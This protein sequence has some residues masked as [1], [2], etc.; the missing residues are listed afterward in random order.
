MLHELLGS[1]VKQGEPGDIKKE[2]MLTKNVKIGNGGKRSE[3]NIRTEAGNSYRII[4]VRNIDHDATQQ[5]VLEKI[6]VRAVRWAIDADVKGGTRFA[7]RKIIVRERVKYEKYKIQTK[8]RRALVLEAINIKKKKVYINSNIYICIDKDIHVPKNYLG[9]QN[10]RLPCKG[11][12]GSP[13]TP[14]YCIITINRRTG[15]ELP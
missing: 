13:L 11:S 14:G 3:L 15:F 7:Q 12:A 4:G 9:I 6:K 5:L 1:P 10:F 2:L 8:R